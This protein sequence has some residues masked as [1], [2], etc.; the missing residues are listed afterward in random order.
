MSF[1]KNLLIALDLVADS[2][3]RPVLESN[4]ALGVF[5]HFGYVF[6]NVL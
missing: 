2:K 6:L 1:L 4:T 5:A 3:V